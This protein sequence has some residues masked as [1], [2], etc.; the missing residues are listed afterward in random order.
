VRAVRSTEDSED[1]LSAC[2][3]D[4]V[5]DFRVPQ[6]A[7]SRSTVEME[8]RKQLDSALGRNPSF[9]LAECVDV[10][11]W[12]ADS[13]QTAEGGAASD[14]DDDE[15]ADLASAEILTEMRFR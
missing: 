2:G 8:S 15:L 7:A 10:R 11:V 3:V 14:I 4:G 6:D 5:A 13:E 1:G 9:A 12:S